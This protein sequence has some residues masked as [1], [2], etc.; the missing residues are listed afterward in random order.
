MLYVKKICLF[1]FVIFLFDLILKK[2]L[3][4]RLKLKMWK[5]YNTY[6]NE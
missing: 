6:N 5:I 4:N 1:L 3:F 2:E